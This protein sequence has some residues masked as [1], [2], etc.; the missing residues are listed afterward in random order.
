M[1]DDLDPELDAYGEDLT[2]DFDPLFGE[3]LPGPQADGTLVAD[4]GWA[5]WGCLKRSELNT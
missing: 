2:E 3:V 1:S 4:L 5:G